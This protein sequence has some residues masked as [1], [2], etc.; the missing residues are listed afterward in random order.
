M[1]QLA[2][3]AI[4]PCRYTWSV[5]FPKKFPSL[6]NF[7]NFL[8]TTRLQHSMCLHIYT[9]ACTHSSIYTNVFCCFLLFAVFSSIRIIAPL[10][11]LLC[12]SLF[13]LYKSWNYFHILPPFLFFNQYI[14]YHM[15]DNSWVSHWWICRLLPFAVVDFAVTN[16]AT[17]TILAQLRIGVMRMGSEVRLPLCHICF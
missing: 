16:L 15:F 5:L 17:M 11:R 12:I 7:S 4:S 9:H 8:Y 6:T 10:Y 2:T 13:S 3:S 1:F 14:M